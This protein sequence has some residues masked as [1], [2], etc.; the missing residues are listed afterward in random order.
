MGRD[1]GNGLNMGTGNGKVAIAYLHNTEVGA[2][3]MASM[4][5]LLVRESGTGRIGARLARFSGANVSHGRNQIVGMFLDTEHEWLLTL[6]TDI[7]FPADLVE[8]LLE[9][10][11]ATERPVVAGLYFGS[12]EGQLWP[13]L[14]QFA[15][16]P[17][18]PSG[19]QT[20]RLG[21]YPKELMQVVATGAGCM[22]IHRSVLE[23]MR[24]AAFDE[25]FPYYQETGYIN[26]KVTGEDV[27]FCLRV[28]KLG[29]PVYVDTRIELGHVKPMVLD[30]TLF[31]VLRD[32]Q[33][34]M[35]ALDIDID[36]LPE[37]VDPPN[38]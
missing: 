18:Q 4:I 11:D 1:Q 8:R 27:T 7:Q 10:A 9:Q 15:D 5:D 34:R 29:H 3:F 22:L 13:L 28:Q 16:A 12:S 30:E 38:A 21:E 20:M 2:H 14:Y 24:D 19:V 6:D 23:E 31:H 36:A 35:A 26:G 32:A 17:D 37:P 33:R 25:A